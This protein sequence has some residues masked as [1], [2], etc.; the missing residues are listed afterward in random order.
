MITTSERAVEKL[1][2]QLINKCLE[3]GIGF[4]MDVNTDESGE[5]TFSIR[6]DRQHQG[7]EV[8]E[9]DGIKIILDPASAC[10]ISDYQLDYQDDPDSGF[11]LNTKQEV[12]GGHN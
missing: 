8:I 5:T 3:A 11:F 4:R 1:R 2:E 12:I 9:V 6:I 7:D 10:Q